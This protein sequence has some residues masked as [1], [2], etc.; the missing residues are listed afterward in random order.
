MKTLNKDVNQKIVK[1]KNR[2][3]GDVVESI[4]YD[5][6]ITTGGKD[7]IKVYNPSNP[8]RTFLVNKEAYFV[9]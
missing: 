9:V 3:T 4:E 5:H 8:K 1:L 7:F 2:Y 6:N